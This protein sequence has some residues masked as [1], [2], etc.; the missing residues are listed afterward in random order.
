MGE[1]RLRSRHI[2]NKGV[3][4]VVRVT[5]TA[6]GHS[7]SYPSTL[8]RNPETSSVCVVLQV[9]HY[10][11]FFWPS[12]ICGTK[13]EGGS[14]SYFIFKSHCLIQKLWTY[15]F[16]PYVKGSL[17][18]EEWFEPLLLGPGFLHLGHWLFWVFPLQETTRT[19]TLLGS[20]LPMLA[21]CS[22]ARRMRCCQIG[23]S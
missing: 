20:M 4:R 17:N 21:L 16:F 3:A 14:G 22:E 23:M 1:T 7:L 9:W 8:R 19:S 18:L 2:L 5:F 15:F 6:Q 10:C 12:M 13:W 11:P